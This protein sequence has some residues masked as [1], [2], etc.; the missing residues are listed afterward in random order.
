M[1]TSG[2]ANYNATV[3]SIIKGALR[4]V[5]AYASND[6][7][8]SGQMADALEAMNMMIKT[9]QIDGF[10][11]LKKFVTVS[12]TAGTAA[13]D[14]GPSTIGFR[15]TRVFMASRRDAN[16][17]DVPLTMI[18]RQE[19]Q[20]IPN[21][22]TQSVPV[23]AYY[24]PQTTTGKIYVWPVPSD[25][26]NSLFMTVD[27]PL[28]DLLTGDETVDCPPEW[29]EAFKFGLAIRI[30]PEYGINIGERQLLQQEYQT[31]KQNLMSYDREPTP[32]YLSVEYRT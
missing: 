13:Y 31:L 18:S 15:P 17:I 25:D 26:T 28:E 4:M 20:D 1:T 24:D 23:Q 22:T 14:L 27:R 29:M 2:T 19:Y 3:D 5:G 10:L 11:W 30:A 9:W 21:K 7:P 16:G 12:L 8:T 32:T 6:N